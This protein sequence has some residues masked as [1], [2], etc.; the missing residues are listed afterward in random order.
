M[1][2]TGGGE[3]SVWA[4]GGTAL[5]AALLI[6]AGLFQGFE[7]LAALLDDD[8]LLRPDGY[9]FAL[10]LTAWG[11]IHVLLGVALALT[12]VFLLRGSPVAAGVAIAV[13]GLSAV[14]NFLFLPYYPLWA[15]LVIAL[16]VFVVWAILRTTTSGWASR[17]QT[18]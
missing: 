4:V 15:V 9:A 14:S 5:A 2:R 16:D 13:A 8:F 12:G 7:G 1:R 17:P 6:M 11:W 10:D 18:D 3:P